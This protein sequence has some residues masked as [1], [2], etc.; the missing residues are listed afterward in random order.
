MDRVI[1]V[2][3]ENKGKSGEVIGMF[4]G[5]GVCVVKTEDG[6]EYVAKLDEIKKVYS[7]EKRTVIGLPKEMVEEI[8]R[9]LEILVDID[10]GAVHFSSNFDYGTYTPLECEDMFLDTLKKK[11]GI[12]LPS[13]YD[14]I[15][16]FSA[17]EKQEFD[18]YIGIMF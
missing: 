9:E 17:N 15:N 5:A 2:S 12:E 6:N 11:Y 8:T 14:K 13:D 1:I 18:F 3:G 16:L 7:I 10:K 4:F